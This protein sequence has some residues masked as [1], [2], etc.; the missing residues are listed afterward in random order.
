MPVKPGDQRRAGTGCV[1]G[2]KTTG[3]RTPTDHGYVNGCAMA[4][5][6]NRT[7]A[8]VAAAVTSATWAQAA[9]T[10][11]IPSTI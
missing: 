6:A 1:G 3:A 4:N 5:P 11:A 2:C 10:A 7:T 9:N 8:A